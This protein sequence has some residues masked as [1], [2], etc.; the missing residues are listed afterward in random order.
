MGVLEP[1]LKSFGRRIVFVVAISLA[2]VLAAAAAVFAMEIHREVTRDAETRFRDVMAVA[3]PAFLD[4]QAREIAGTISGTLSAG[5]AFVDDLAASDDPARAVALRRD[6][7]DHLR[8]NAALPGMFPLFDAEVLAAVSPGGRL[9]WTR[10]APDDAS[11][12]DSRGEPWIARAL[13]GSAG[14]MV[15]AKGDPAA[16]AWIPASAPAG[17]L[18]VAVARPISLDRDGAGG[19]VIAGRALSPESLARLSAATGLDVVLRTAHGSGGSLAL[20][21][22][23]AEALHALPPGRSTPL[24]VAGRER[25]ALRV[26]E[27][28]GPSAGAGLKVFL[29]RDTERERRLIRRLD[30]WLAGLGI[31]TLFLGVLLGRSFSRPMRESVDALVEGTEAIRMKRYGHRVSVTTNDELATLAESM[32][33]MAERLEKGE[34]VES[35]LKLFVPPAYV[36]YILTHRDE[37]KLGGE[38]R[39]M[40]I[41]FSDVIGFTRIA[42]RKDPEGLVATVNAHFDLCSR[43][44]ATH[45][46]TIDKFIGDAVMAFWNAPVPVEDHASRALLAALEMVAVGDYASIDLEKKGEPATRCRVGVHTGDAIAGLVGGVD[47]RNYTALGDVVNV[48]ARLESANKV[49]GTR[50]LTTAVT[51]EAAGGAV[52]ARFLDRVRVVGR[53]QPIE[54]HEVLCEQG[55][56]APPRAPEAEYRQAWDLYANARF[57]EALE[58]F[59]ALAT[60]FPEDGPVAVLRAR[61]RDYSRITV[62]NFDGVFVMT[63]K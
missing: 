36:D 30:G 33:R 2:V 21:P 47:R 38:R 12:S 51:R 16:A 55:S 49:Y 48:A 27:A 24:V 29:L 20:S 1:L 3:L 35:S 53:E 42:E 9:L 46:G 4:D 44:I 39:H 10:A 54:V 37:L 26:V 57:G 17:Q 61:C 14:S 62:E 7:A 59:S 19:V 25:R 11:F 5:G 13:A 34:F 23:A 60:R 6:V 31:A 43:V 50:I 8:A 58:A 18:F 52:V 40:S 41:L 32:N 15:L 28:L 45:L 63:E 22:E 56:A